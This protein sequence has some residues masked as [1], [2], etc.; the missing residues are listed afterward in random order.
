MCKDLT[1]RSLSFKLNLMGKLRTFFRTLAKSATSPKY[2][3]EVVQAKF[4]FSLKF[5]FFYFF[6][7]ALLG[8]AYLTP[9]V[10]LPM[11]RE[12]KKLPDKILEAYPAELEVKIKDGQV[13]TNVQEPY[14]IPF[15]TN[16]FPVKSLP[17]EAYLDVGGTRQPIANLSNLDLL[18]IDT[19]AQVMDIQKYKT[20]ALLTKDSISMV[21]E[22]GDIR[23]YPLKEV[24]NVTIN[25][26]VVFSVI[27]VIAPYLKYVVPGLAVCI[28]LGLAIFW[29]LGKMFYLLLFS[30]L[31]LIVGKIFRLSLSYGKYYQIGLHTMVVWSTLEGIMIL[32]RIRLPIP[33][34][35]TIILLILTTIALRG[36]KREELSSNVPDS[37]TTV[38]LKT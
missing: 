13:S 9:M 36:L 16:L 24:K 15:P 20:L 38:S 5:F 34:L 31:T 11:N 18:T 26:L 1:V 32:A 27:Q 12:V 6:L 28:F 3:A 19:K 7:Y 29:P 14:S 10:F 4:S 22:Q 37:P 35:G 21:G 17:S 23:V 33:F 2:Y 25:K 30:V 8:I